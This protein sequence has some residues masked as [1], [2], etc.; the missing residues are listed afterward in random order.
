MAKC[1]A[2]SLI[3]PFVHI[4]LSMGPIITLKILAIQMNHFGPGMIK[5]VMLLQQ[6]GPTL[7]VAVII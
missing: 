2:Q 7:F 3:R 1:E 5:D 4:Y 6:T